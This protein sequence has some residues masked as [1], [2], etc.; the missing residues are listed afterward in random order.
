MCIYIPG[1]MPCPLQQE[2]V[3]PIS[4]AM[5][6]TMI[7]L[8]VSM[9]PVS[10]AINSGRDRIYFEAGKLKDTSTVRAKPDATTSECPTRHT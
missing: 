2:F 10:V 9:F 8:Y 7:H 6:T 4:L 5:W 1:P 3:S